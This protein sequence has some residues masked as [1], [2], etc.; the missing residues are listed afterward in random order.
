[1]IAKQLGTT[2]AGLKAFGEQGK[3]TA[4]VVVA[5]FAAQREEIDRKFGK[6]VATF[7]DLWTVLHNNVQA[8][9]GQLVEAVGGMPALEKAFASAGKTIAEMGHGIAVA[10]QNTRTWPVP[11]PSS[12]A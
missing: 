2:R 6:S 4:D 7:S 11:V 5:A 8:A 10:V 9:V 12:V 3:I 1:M